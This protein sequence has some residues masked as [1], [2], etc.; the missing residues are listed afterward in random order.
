[1]VE[2]IAQSELKESVYMTDDLTRLE[3]IIFR[4]Y[5]IAYSSAEDTAVSSGSLTIT[6]LAPDITAYPTPPIPLVP[7]V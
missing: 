4:A 5:G 7:S 3:L 1:M 2:A 6:D